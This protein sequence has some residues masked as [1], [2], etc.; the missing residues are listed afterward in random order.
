MSALAFTAIAA[1]GF[2]NQAQAQLFAGESSGTWG[3]PE[4]G[5]NVDAVYTGVGTNQFA[6]GDAGTFGTGANQLI[7][8]GNPISSGINSLFKVGDLTY[9]NGTV[10]LGSQVESV[11]LDILLSLTIPTTFGEVFSFDFELVNTNNTG[12]PDENADYVYIIDNFGDRSFSFSGKEY[13]LE[14]TGFSQDDGTTSVSQFRVREGETTTAAIFARIT[15]APPSPETPPPPPPKQVPE[16][17]SAAGVSL[18]GIY[19]ITRQ[20]SATPKR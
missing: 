14:L 2:C 8:T 3:E 18:L 11:P 15:E 1:V 13:T 6:W 10:A 12:T 5:Q 9:F 17:A 4:I 19:L 16:P 7:F 20:Q